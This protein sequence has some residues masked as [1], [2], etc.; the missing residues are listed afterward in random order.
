M[1][2]LESKPGVG[3]VDGAVRVRPDLVAEQVHARLLRGVEALGEVEAERYADHLDVGS[4]HLGE[5]LM[6]A[7]R[8][9][10]PVPTGPCRVSR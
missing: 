2:G 8:S 10:P 5:D 9:Y 3:D 4:V 6:C 7:I 1:T